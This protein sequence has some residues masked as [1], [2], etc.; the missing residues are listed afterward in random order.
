MLA[1]LSS[2]ALVRWAVTGRQ[3]PSPFASQ[4]PQQLNVAVGDL[5]TWASKAGFPA[6]DRDPTHAKSVG[7]ITLQS[8][9]GPTD[10]ARQLWPRE[11]RFARQSSGDAL[12]NLRDW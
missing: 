10:C 6:C 11:T 7:D 2:T 3:P 1:T 5:A 4:I 8:A 12:L 9:S